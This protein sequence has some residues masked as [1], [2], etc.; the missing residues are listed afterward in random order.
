[1][2]NHTLLL[3]LIS[4]LFSCN[5]KRADSAYQ[6]TYEYP[7]IVYILA[8]DLGYGDLQCYNPESKIPTPNIDRLSEQGMRFWDAHSPSGV[9]TPSRYGILTGRYCWRSRMPLGVLQGYGRS[10]VKKERKTVAELLAE[11]DYHT[12][13]IGKWHLGLDWALSAAEEDVLQ[14]ENTVVS[15]RGIISNMDPRYIDFGRPPGNGPTRHGFDYSFILPASLDMPP[16]CFLEND[17]L[18]AP[19]DTETE[20]NDLNTNYTEA[21][22][23]PGLIATGFEFEDVLP[24]FTKKAMDY[25]DRRAN[26]SKPFFLY[27]PLAAPHTPW[28]PTD[29]YD[30][31]SEAGTYG[32]FV[33]MVDAAVGVVL[34]SLK[35][36]GL[37]E[38]TLVIFTSDNGPY[39]RPADKQKY[40]HQAA[41]KLRGMKADAWEGGHRVPFVVRWP[42]RIRPGS[43]NDTPVSLTDFYATCAELLD[44]PLAKDQ[45]EDSQS[46]LPILLE[47][48]SSGNPRRPIIQQS[49]GGYF[50]V[51]KDNWKLI[52]G[53]GSGGFS[54]P[55]Q[56]EAP[57][58]GPTGQLYNLKEDISEQNNLYQTYPDVVQELESILKEYQQTGRSR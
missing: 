58:H 55:R 30:G 16:Y 18:T 48:V 35:N 52:T 40:R 2:K 25:I 8:D 44:Q 46:L 38:N 50:A 15:D 29:T 26:A 54:Q 10:F 56:L 28:V 17:R 3:I 19:L 13:V 49:S 47:N 5:D 34:E 33:N 20:G 51:R 31:K 6:A 22:W 4:L 27:L 21:F 36:H 12:A 9:C 14:D 1:M 11:H 45:A 37:E 41:G 57:E 23:R 39:W 32:D 43:S 7:N 42:V 53:L 24:T